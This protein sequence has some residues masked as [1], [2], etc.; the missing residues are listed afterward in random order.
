[1]TASETGYAVLSAEL[2]RLAK[3]DGEFLS[4]TSALQAVA[5][6]EL[7]RGAFPDLGM[8]RYWD[9]TFRVRPGHYES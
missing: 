7:S 1:M 6:P 9:I 5:M 4:E 3:G 8:M 2:R